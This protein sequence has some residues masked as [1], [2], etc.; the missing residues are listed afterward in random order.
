MKNKEFYVV[1][2]RDED[3]MYIGEVPQ[4]KA[5][6]SQGE[7]IDELITNIKEVIKM[8]LEELG[9]ESITEFIGVSK[10][11]LSSLNYQQLQEK[12]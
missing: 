1:I 4:L 2:E 10:V 3:G 9:E 6:Y 12:N 11:V 8:C 7:T 5:C